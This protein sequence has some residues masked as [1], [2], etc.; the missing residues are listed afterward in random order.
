MQTNNAAR[1]VVPFVHAS[2]LLAAKHDPRVLTR[3]LEAQQPGLTVMLLENVFAP[4]LTASMPC[5]RAESKTVVVGCV[6]LLCE[7]DELPARPPAWAKVL[8]GVLALLAP[9][10]SAAGGDDAD[11]GAQ[12]EEEQ[13]GYDAAYSQLRFAQADAHDALAVVPDARLFAAQTLKANGAKLAPLLQ[14]L[15]PEQN[16]ALQ[17]LLA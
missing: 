1:Y 17:A 14:Q 8:E 13:I 9:A 7:A 12:A 11:A 2:C 15:P 5:S 10:A 6:R 16:A 4:Q 3:T